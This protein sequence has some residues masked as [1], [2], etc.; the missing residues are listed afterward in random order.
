MNKQTHTLVILTPAFAEAEGDSWLP[1]Q[2]SFVRTVNRL[3]PELKVV[4]LSFHFPERRDTYNWYGN[5]VIALGGGLKGKWNSLKLWRRAW[6]ALQ[7]L[8]RKQNLLGIFSFFCSESAFIGHHF[9]KRNGVQ[10]Y[11]WI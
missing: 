9:A 7:H 2:E 5:E 6:K 3:F 8:R 10:H 4:I 1:A 11:I